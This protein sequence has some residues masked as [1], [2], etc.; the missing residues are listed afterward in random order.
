MCCDALCNHSPHRKCAPPLHNPTTQSY[1]LG[2]I[3]S[4]PTAA[5]KGYILGGLMWFCIPFALATSL[6]LAAVALDLPISVADANAGL[7]PPAVAQ[8]LLGDFGAVLMTIMLFMAV[9][10][11]G[12]AEMVAVASLVAYDL[13]RTYI[14]K[15]ATGRQILHV[16][17]AMIVIFGLLMGGLA[18]GLFA[19]GL[20]LGFVYLFMGMRCFVWAIGGSALCACATK[21]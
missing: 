21:H 9:T 13:Y 15:N 14:N 17:R 7:V 19:I 1:W 5:Y 11:T 12:S 4:K 20:S 10:G 6:G 18:I 8:F 16:S 2:A 3:A